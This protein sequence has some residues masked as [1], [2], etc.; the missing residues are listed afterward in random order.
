MEISWASVSS[1]CSN[2]H[3][4]HSEDGTPQ[5]P[6]PEDPLLETD[7]VG[8]HSSNT[9]QTIITINGDRI[10]IVFNTS[11][12]PL[13]PLAGG[14]FYNVSLG[15]PENDV[16]GHNVWGISDEDSNLLKAPGDIM[17]CANSCHESNLTHCQSTALLV[18]N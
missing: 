18:K 14:N 15:G 16:Y 5:T 11:G 4:M 2:C 10:P 3:V 12:Y 8:C 6:T 17:N 7:C 9:N 13:Q 1:E